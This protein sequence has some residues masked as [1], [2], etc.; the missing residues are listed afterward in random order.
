[1]KIAIDAGHGSDTSGKRTPDEYREHYAN[2]VV[3]NYLYDILNAN[4]SQFEII[5]TGW[6][7]DDYLDVKDT[8]LI[9]DT[10]SSNKE[11]TLKKAKGDVYFKINPH[12]EEYFYE[13]EMKCTS[14]DYS[15]YKYLK[16]NSYDY[17]TKYG[18]SLS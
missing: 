8:A 11:Y 14:T 4:P 17:K 6:N 13:H 16:D 3:A 1:M 15:A 2:V 7:D 12:D 18:E 5:R 9:S 10:I